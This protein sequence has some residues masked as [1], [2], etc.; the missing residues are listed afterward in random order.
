MYGAELPKGK[1]RGCSA[2]PRRPHQ[3]ALG[4]AG[5]RCAMS[6]QIHFKFKNARD[7]DVV[8]FDGAELPLDALKRAIVEKKDLA[9]SGVDLVVTNAQSGQGAGWRRWAQ[10]A[11]TAAARAAVPRAR[12]A[13]A[14]AAT[15]TTPPSSSLPRSRRVRAVRRRA[16][17]R[18]RAREDQAAACVPGGAG[19]RRAGCSCG[20]RR[21]C[22]RDRGATLSPARVSGAIGWRCRCRAPRGV[23]VAGCR[24]HRPCAA[25]ARVHAVRP[26]AR[27][28]SC[29]SYTRHRA[30][31]ARQHA[32]AHADPSSV[33][34]R[35]CS[36]VASQVSS[37]A[38]PAAPPRG[39]T[40]L[41]PQPFAGGS[42][43][44]GGDAV[45]PAPCRRPIGLRRA[46]TAAG[47]PSLRWRRT[48][49]AGR[50]RQRAAVG[51]FV[52]SGRGR[53]RGQGC[54][55]PTRGAGGTWGRAARPPRRVPR[56]LDDVRAPAPSPSPSPTCR[57]VCRA[58]LVAPL[59]LRP[60]PICPLAV[61]RQLLCVAACRASPPPLRPLGTASHY[62][63][64]AVAL[65]SV[66]GRGRGGWLGG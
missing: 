58:Y 35:V 41:E 38:S 50:H 43:S 13:L 10:G 56:R 12:R 31:V 44:A 5:A 25:R 63:A 23:R 21:C 9:A 26:N 49:A 29:L 34:S 4:G 17:E 27:A 30:G 65:L 36:L 8:L 54:A 40:A 7:G 6:S 64:R 52:G 28:R 51:T 11:S 39:P 37:D 24:R 48:R 14:R 47:S 61:Q 18:V 16:Q 66:G 19:A 3:A 42:L 45:R 46:C 53:G 62:A 60:P 33:T 22:G 59:C 1:R 15:T 32:S 57:R 55:G 20:H 2:S